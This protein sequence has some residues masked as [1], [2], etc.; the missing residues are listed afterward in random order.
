[1]LFFARTAGRALPR[2]HDRPPMRN[3]LQ[4]R[5]FTAALLLLCAPATAAVPA[6]WLT[7]L[8]AARTAAAKEDRMIL[9]DLW[10][11]W[12]GWCKVLE[13]EVFGTEAFRAQTSDFVLVQ[14]DTE[15][16]GEGSALQER[17]SADTLPTTLI[18]DAELTEV[19]RVEGF[20]PVDEYLQRIEEEVV[21]H[22]RL[23]ARFEKA[24][25]GGGD[26]G[27]L[28]GLAGELHHRKDHRRAALL[29]ER[30]R[31]RAETPE[32]AAYYGYRLAE[33]LIAG[34]RQG[35]ATSALG[36]ARAVAS[37]RGDRTLLEALDVLRIRLAEQQ[38]SCERT[39]LAAREFLATYPASRHRSYAEQAL[40][41][42]GKANA[43]A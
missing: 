38:G 26:P 24:I 27:T 18:L 39:A 10:A 17:F 20:A 19:G 8:D 22:S 6:G 2:S 11:D 5:L 9:V 4:S 36:A 30:L 1:M 41:D 23:I 43:C 21:R 37:E 34:G 3:S 42:A 32:A 13:K 7:D 12:C 25:A 31:E 15:D 14:L 33:V 28:D 16:G 29:Y 35:E 40:A